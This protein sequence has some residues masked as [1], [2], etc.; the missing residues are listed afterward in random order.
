MRSEYLTTHPATSASSPEAGHWNVEARAF[1]IEPRGYLP[2]PR[3]VRHFPIAETET[4]EGFLAYE[5]ALA[6]SRWR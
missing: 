2:A 5:L 4:R 6:S 3:R 1:A